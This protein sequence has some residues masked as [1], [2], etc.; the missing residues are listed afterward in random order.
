MTVKFED[1]NNYLFIKLDGMSRE[2]LIKRLRYR[3]E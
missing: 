1:L 3:T 2:E